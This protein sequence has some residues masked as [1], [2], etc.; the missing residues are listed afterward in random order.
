M[1][2]TQVNSDGVSDGSI[3]NADIKS[4][5]AIAKAKL[6]GLDIVNADINNSAAIATSKISGL[7][8]SAT[9]DTTNADNIGSGTLAAARVADLAASKITSGTIATARLG[10]GTASNAN[11]LRGDGTW[12]AVP[13]A[14]EDANIRRDLNTLALQTAVDTNRKAYNLQ[15]SFIDQF[16]DSSGITTKTN[17]KVLSEAVTTVYAGYDDN[18]V[19]MWHCNSSAMIDDSQNGIT[20]ITFHSHAGYSTTDKKFG[21][22]SIHFDG[23]EDYM[24]TGNLK[25]A[26]SG[27]IAVPTTGD[28]TLDFWAKYN[29]RAA[30]DRMIST[31]NNGTPSGGSN[32]SFT[33]GY[34][35]SNRF[36]IYSGDADAHWTGWPTQDTSWHH[37]A[38][39]RD[40]TTLY[41]WKDGSYQ[42]STT[43]LDN[44]DIFGNDANLFLGMRGGSAGEDFNGYLDEI[45]LSDNKRYTAST[46]FTV[47]SSE[48]TASTVNNA[49]GSIV[50]SVST[51][52]DARTKVSGVLLY[53]NVSGTC[54]LGTDLKVYFSC[55]NGTNWTELGAS[56][57]TAGSDF[58]TGIKTVYLAEKTC[59][60][61]TQIK[62]KV[63]WANQSNGS[64]VTELHGIALNY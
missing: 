9:T 39:M 15:N 50:S 20:G 29:S 51:A 4:D 14:Y 57:F 42:S 38:F 22:G 54:T 26:T 2:L 23:S 63:E 31:G 56:D 32:T 60:S 30:A 49:T 19:I 58:T 34:N 5:A 25:T 52:S 46:N 7:A 10:S 59:T 1:G 62:Y 16:E 28:F 8:A 36:N 41:A 24:S 3:K 18:T 44:H 35:Q 37:Y 55:N 13:P 17:T 53:K 12:T 47:P 33:M 40:G 27:G 21:T 64:K 43:I 45:R 48:Y 6:A 11:Y 61:G